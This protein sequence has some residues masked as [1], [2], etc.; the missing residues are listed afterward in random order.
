MTKQVPKGQLG[1]M[2]AG[3]GSGTLLLNIVESMPPELQGLATLIAPWVSVGVYWGI[4]RLLSAFIERDTKRRRKQAVR[5]LDELAKDPH[6]DPEMIA[7]LRSRIH[8][9][10]TAHVERLIESLEKD[11]QLAV[12]GL[13]GLAEEHPS[14]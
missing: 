7:R 3:A 6:G 4:G 8:A 13:A 12:Q 9:T 11:S 14:S 10:Q 2:L 5:M 1:P